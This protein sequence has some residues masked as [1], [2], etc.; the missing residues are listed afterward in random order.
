VIAR[1]LPIVNLHGDPARKARNT[2]SRTAGH[3]YRAA[4]IVWGLEMVNRRRAF[5]FA[6][7]ALSA[8][9]LLQSST[10]R[11]QQAFQRYFPLLVDLDGWQGKTPDGV[12]MEM[13]DNSMITATREYQRGTARLHA[14]ILFG[15]AAQGALAMTKTGMNIETSDGRMNTSTIN[16]MTVTRTF[17]FKDKSGAILVALGASGLLSVSFNGI[18]DDEALTLAKNFDW[19]AIQAAQPKS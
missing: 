10:A 11:A 19:K 1:D 7:I 16:G 9:W 5:C 2:I 17:N 15:A 4:P 13:P 18:P 8:G 6:F 3:C 12:S 14:Q